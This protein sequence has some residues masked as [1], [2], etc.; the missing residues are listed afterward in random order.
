MMNQPERPAPAAPSA[1]QRVDD[2]W[3][4]LLAGL[5]WLACILIALLMVVVCLDVFTRAF[6]L[7]GL[8]W[9]PE[10]AEYV[11]YLST[12]L[13]TPWLLREGKHIRIDMVLTGVPPKTGWVTEIVADAVGMIT[14]FALC[15]AGFNTILA[16]ARQG[17]LVFKIFIIPEWWVLTPAPVLVFMLGVE[18]IF[19]LRRLLTGPKQPRQEATSA[20]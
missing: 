15:A 8:A 12:F 19:R 16:S 20:A 11:L 4:K 6:N 7:G 2:A 5:A 1:F 14:C 10:I 18:F 9:A 13:A 17:A 3:G